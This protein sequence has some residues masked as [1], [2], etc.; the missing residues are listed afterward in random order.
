MKVI[1]PI[2]NTIEDDFVHPV[3]EH[4]CDGGAQQRSIRKAFILVSRRLL[5]GVE[6]VMNGLTP[7]PQQAVFAECIHH[8]HG[9]SCHKGGAYVLCD[10]LPILCTEC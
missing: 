9:V 8:L 4:G 2:N 7:E 3:R 10:I 5:L 1:V 6:M